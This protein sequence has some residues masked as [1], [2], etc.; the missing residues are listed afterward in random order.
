MRQ[1]SLPVTKYP[2]ETKA[3]IALQEQLLKIN[4]AEAAS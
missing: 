2:T 1:I 3:R 4:G